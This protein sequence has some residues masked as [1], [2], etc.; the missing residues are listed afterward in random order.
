MATTNTPPTRSST[1][2]RPRTIATSTGMVISGVR[3]PTSPDRTRSPVG[4]SREL[5]H[6]TGRGEPVSFPLP[7]R[8]AGSPS[9]STTSPRVLNPRAD[10][11]QARARD[12][13]NSG[14]HTI[15]LGAPGRDGARVPARCENQLRERDGRARALGN[16]PIDNSRLVRELA[17]STRRSVSASCR[18]STTSARITES[19]R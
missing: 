6:A 16:F 11:R 12:L 2:G 5:H 18:S 7:R 3:P 8:H 17:C 13:H 1:N 9:M 19:R 14:G 10:V 4:R 15:S